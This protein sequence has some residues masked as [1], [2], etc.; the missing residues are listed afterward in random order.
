[1]Y[2]T[3][4]YKQTQGLTVRKF[5]TEEEMFAYLET[6]RG[7]GHRPDGVIVDVLDSLQKVVDILWTPH[8]YLIKDDIIYGSLPFNTRYMMRILKF[9]LAEYPT[10]TYDTDHYKFLFDQERFDG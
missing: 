10:L 5:S 9:E 3:I 6:L 2:R 1:M 7:G 4:I 8:L